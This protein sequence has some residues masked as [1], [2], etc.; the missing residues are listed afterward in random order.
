MWSQLSRPNNID[1]IVNYVVNVCLKRPARVLHEIDA[2][3]G[4]LYLRIAAVLVHSGLHLVVTMKHDD[5]KL[6]ASSRGGYHISLTKNVNLRE[7]DKK[8]SH[9]DHP[10]RGGEVPSRGS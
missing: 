7:L 10:A 8:S 5:A 1:A 6:L 3:L 4:K 2:K 9:P